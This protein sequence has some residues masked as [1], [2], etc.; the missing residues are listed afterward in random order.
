MKQNKK[1]H[2]LGIC[3]TFMG[4]LALIAKS[5]GFDV[6]GSD[7]EAYPPMGD[8]LKSQGIEIYQGY[9]EKQLSIYKPD[10]I[11]IG[12]ALGRGHLVVEAILNEKLP[13]KSGPQWL[14]E[15][16]LAKKKVIAISGTHGKTTTTAMVIKILDDAK[17]NPSF[18][19]GGVANDFPL[20]SRITDSEY[21]V[22]EADEYDTAFF[23]KRSKFVHYSPDILIMNNLEF[24]HADIFENL[25]Q[26]KRQFHHLIR[27][28]PKNASVIFNSDDQNLKAV[29]D[30]GL[31][32]EAISFGY[33]NNHQQNLNHWH[34]KILKEDC[35][36]F[37]VYYKDKKQGEISWDLIGKH[38]LY[39]ALAAIAASFRAGVDPN[40]AINA[41][42]QFRGVKRR[43]ENF[44]TKDHVYFYDD[45]AHHPTAIETTLKSMRNKIGQAQLIAILE[46]R[47]NTMKMG[48]HQKVLADAL[49]IADHIFVFQPENVGL[50]WLDVFN[51][52]KLNDQVSISDSVD[53]IIKNLPKVIKNEAHV[54]IMSNGSFDQIY[55][56]I[57]KIE[58]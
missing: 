6:S 54:V 22:I 56:K 9:D 7:K 31:W 53:K 28:M 34:Y 40:V 21:F 48:I 3:G 55:E 42:N 4:S 36:L 5:L 24:D 44:Y 47:S 35:S 29:L 50:Q 30:Q 52:S 37:E 14:Y 2:I 41:L 38:N 39:N 27:V 19:I 11:I 17:L 58:L 16:V 25:D 13:F 18:L 26:I 49:K 57:K 45:F 15:N 12:N 32:S 46:P 10:E 1:I 23:D 8:L 51:N 43:L 33:L 20:S